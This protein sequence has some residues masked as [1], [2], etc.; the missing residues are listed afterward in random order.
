M[1]ACYVRHPPHHCVW[2]PHLLRGRGHEAFSAHHPVQPL[3]LGKFPS[4][5][6]PIC[7]VAWTVSKHWAGISRGRLL[8]CPGFTDWA[9]A[10]VVLTS[11]VNRCGVSPLKKK[12]KESLEEVWLPHEAT[13]TLF[14]NSFVSRVPCC[15]ISK[16]GNLV[17]HSPFGTR[18]CA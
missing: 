2:I 18:T 15:S 16:K 10:C 3:L 8:G 7:L 9:S 6:S 1:V 4:R 17:V 11:F 13:S 12:T 5:L 14:P